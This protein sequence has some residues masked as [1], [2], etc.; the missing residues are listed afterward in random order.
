MPLEGSCETVLIAAHG[1]FNR[2]LLRTIVPT[3]LKDFWTIGLPNCAV[4]ILS[5]ENGKFEVLEMGKIYYDTP[6]NVRP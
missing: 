1:A 5:L 2:C 6:V 4:S 3:P